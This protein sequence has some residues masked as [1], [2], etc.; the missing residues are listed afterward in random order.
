M[1]LMKNSL[2]IRTSICMEMTD[3]R[4]NGSEDR[5]GP[6]QQFP[7]ISL[8][9]NFHFRLFCLPIVSFSL[10]KQFTLL[11]LAFILFSRILFLV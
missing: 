8:L 1:F 10:L 9:L 2:K 11:L 3:Q 6:N 5:T 4:R 7:T